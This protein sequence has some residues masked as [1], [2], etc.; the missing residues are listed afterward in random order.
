LV[1]ACRAQ[2]HAGAGETRRLFQ[3][4][5]EL[6]KPWLSPETL[7]QTDLEPHLSLVRLCQQAQQEI[8]AWAGHGPTQPGGSASTLGGILG[9]LVKRKD[10]PAFKETMRQ[11][12]GVEL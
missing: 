12:Y 2:A 7:T 5:E 10:R 4:L 8:D 1:R 9:R 11:L 3:R 6:V